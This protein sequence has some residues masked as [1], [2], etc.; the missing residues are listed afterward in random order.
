MKKLLLLAVAAVAGYAILNERPAFL[1]G[2]AP[3]AAVTSL[4]EQDVGSGGSAIAD[5]FA[6]R[7]SDVQ[8]SGEGKVIRLLP[9]DADGSR[10]Q[11]FILRLGG[12]QTVLVSHNIDLAPRV[13][14]LTTGD[15]VGFSGEYEWNEKGGVVHWTHRD[16][17][18][19]HVAGWL[20]H[21]GRLYQ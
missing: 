13:S 21:N 5:A 4:A 14:E 2:P 7:Q 18:G 12:G 19:A 8:V 1:S 20:R 3:H 9:D 11:K 6:R 16:P 15:S 17:R 10:H